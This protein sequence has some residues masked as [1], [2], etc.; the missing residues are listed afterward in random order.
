[1][2]SMVKRALVLPLLMLV[3]LV[4]AGCGSGSGSGGGGGSSADAVS[5]VPAGALAYAT[6]DTDFGSSQLKSAQ[7]VLDKFP[8][9]NTVIHDVLSSAAKQG[10][11][12]RKLSASVGSVLDVAVLKTGTTTAV[13]GFAKP[14]DEQTFDAQLG[15][16]V[17][18][19]VS[20]WTVFAK[21]QAALDAVTSR[22]ASLA[23]DADYKDAL[24]SLPGT[25]DAIV[26][27]FAPASALQSIGNS[28]ATSTIQPFTGAAK[29]FTSA[30][31]SE[32]GN[33]FK[34]ETH[35][36]TT[37]GGSSSGGSGLADEIPSG[38][39]AALSLNGG[40]ISLPA[41]AQAQLGQ[42]SQSAGFDIQGLVG[43][44]GGPV[45]VYVKPGAPIPEVTLAAK[46]TDPAGA[47]QAITSLLTKALASQTN[48]APPQTTTVDGV[49]LKSMNLGPIALYWGRVGDQIAVTDDSN[50]IA[51]IKG[52][53]ASSKL[54]D[55]SLFKGTAKGAGMPSSN[56]GFLYLDAKDALPLIEGFAALANQ[57]IPPQVQS[58]LA[59]LK[60]ALVYGSRNGDV[61]DL[62]V[63]A[64][65]N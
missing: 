42:L 35:A 40:S 50:A 5:L 62:V 51:T 39:I 53:S 23:D 45:I 54:T 3:L 32:G 8:I 48:G 28:S 43:L 7:Q 1:M 14:S 24:G 47:Q 59:P 46:P 61:Q 37:S 49:S 33:S 55:D 56:Q 13:V 57:K 6:I 36:K 19:K 27:A 58:N 26:R 2:R 18:T 38:A 63:F 15:K 25:G 16:L 65:T 34:L 21:T 52:G 44:L 29:W 4:L 9:K 64:S 20:G 60:G 30:L 10:V 11:D 31:T 12:L 41:S 22:T 17:H